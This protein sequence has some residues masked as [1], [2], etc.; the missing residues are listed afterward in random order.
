MVEEIKNH[1][2]SGLKIFIGFIK[3]W[4]ISM[5]FLLPISFGLDLT[6][7]CLTLKGSSGCIGSFYENAIFVSIIIALIPVYK[8][9][10]HIFEKEYDWKWFLLLLPLGIIIILLSFSF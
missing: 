4:L 8:D 6:G 10:K 7:L 5:V 3:T 9:Y 2:H 1:T